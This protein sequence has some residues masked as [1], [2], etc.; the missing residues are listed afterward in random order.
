MAISAKAPTT[1]ELVTELKPKAKK[2]KKAEAPTLDL[3][4]VSVEMITKL[5]KEYVELRMAL[6]TGKEKNTS[7]LK[8]LRKDIARGLTRIKF[9]EI[10]KQDEQ[11]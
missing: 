9:N 2:A 7:K 6:M 4:K 11:A 10:V 1:E 8:A 3:E 5:K